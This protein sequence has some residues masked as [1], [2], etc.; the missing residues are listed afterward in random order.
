MPSEILRDRI[1]AARDNINS[2]SATIGSGEIVVFPNISIPIPEL[3]FP[4]H[5]FFTSVS[6]LYVLYFEG[7]KS[8]LKFLTERAVSLGVDNE[9]SIKKHFTLIHD[10][11]TCLQHNL[12]EYSRDDIAKG[13][14]CLSWIQRIRPNESPMI[15]HAADDSVYWS[16][17]L[18][19]LLSEAVSTLEIFHRT[20]LRINQDEGKDHTIQV[21]LSRIKRE[22][23]CKEWEGILQEVA[24]DLGMSFLDTRS[25]MEKHIEKWNRKLGLLKDEQI[26]RREARKIVEQ[27][28]LEDESIPIPITG[29][30]I[31]EELGLPPGPLVKERLKEARQIYLR[32]PCNRE[33][34]LQRL[35]CTS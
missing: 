20:L 22:I 24:C 12:N 35:G 5:S 31:I 1:L 19:N 32:D 29:R 14:R 28:L 11:R 26:V 2:I 8:S 6:W 27:T 23:P 4:I 9:F 17:L 13:E 30:D 34:L 21:W 16:E 33:K 7:G 3:V 15:W 25:V 18:S 10:L